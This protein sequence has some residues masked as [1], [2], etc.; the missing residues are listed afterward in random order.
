MCT[1]DK[2]KIDKELRGNIQA[3]IKN[4]TD[5]EDDEIKE[6]ISEIV[7]DRKLE[8][9]LAKKSNFGDGEKPFSYRIAV[10]VASRLALYILC[11][12][13][14][15]DVV[16]ET[17]VASGT[18]SS[19]ILRALDKNDR[20]T[21]YS[22]DVPWYTVTQNWKGAFVDGVKTNPIEMQ[23]GWI[24]PNYLRDRWDLTMGLT[25]EKLPALLKKTG[26]VDVF[27]HDSEHSYENMAREF[28]TIWPGLRK[29][30]VMLVHNV[31]K[32]PA[33]A[34]FEDKVGGTSF[35]LSGLNNDG[36]IMTIG[37]KAKE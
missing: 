29:K 17:G 20:G 10:D 13:R 18:S 35:K 24:I 28:K 36:K 25:S 32:T 3:F 14:K 8:N 37:G 31:E 27:F 7:S 1:G 19:Y 23:S 6:Y 15:P 30:G 2:M 26:K 12:A 4:L 11:R 9:S 16:V 34:E 5:A 33:F 22:I 21:L